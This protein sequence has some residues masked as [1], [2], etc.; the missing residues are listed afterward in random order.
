MKEIKKES[1]IEI[2]IGLDEKNHPE[3]IMWS[4][5]DNPVGNEAQEAKAVL[6]SLF[7]KEHKDTFKIDLWTSEMQV[8]EMDRF[9]FQSLK[10]IADTYHRAT[11]NKELANDMQ[12]FVHY[13]GQRTQIIPPET[14][15]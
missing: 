11:G 9:V 2:K 4:S 10:A 15:E 5:D 6:I 3:R 12:K 8:A 1:K 7:D 14:E 13:F